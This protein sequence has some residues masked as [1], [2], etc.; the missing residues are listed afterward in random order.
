MKKKPKT[1]EILLEEGSDWLPFI[2]ANA[3]RAPTRSR[4]N[5]VHAIRF[6]DG[7]IWDAANGW[8]LPTFA[9][10]RRKA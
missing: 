1:V 3:W 8:R 7:S 6:D 2:K 5:Q 9:A 4:P 10:G